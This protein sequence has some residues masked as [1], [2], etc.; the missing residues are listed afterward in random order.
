LYIVDASDESRFEESKIVFDEIIKNQNIGKIPI[1]IL[2]NKCDDPKQF[3]DAQLKI[4]DLFELEKLG[5]RDYII[6]SVSAH[7]GVGVRESVEILI[8]NLEKNARYVDTDGY[9]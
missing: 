9:I 8:Q 4:L 7:T 3:A 2:L 5:E 1:F 6:Q